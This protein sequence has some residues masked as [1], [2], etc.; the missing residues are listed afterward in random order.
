MGRV[1]PAANLGWS[2][3]Q[4]GR[5]A[6]LPVEVPNWQSGP[7]KSCVS[8]RLCP[9]LHTIHNKLPTQ[10]NATSHS[11]IKKYTY[12]KKKKKKLEWE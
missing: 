11:R 4:A 10:E 1:P 2:K 5:G 3:A 6:S 9:V 8:S 12:G 7:Q